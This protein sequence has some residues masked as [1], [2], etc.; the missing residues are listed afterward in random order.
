[1]ILKHYGIEFMT[2]V[3]KFELILMRPY[4]K[5]LIHFITQMNQPI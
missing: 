5:T 3:L 1:M 4:L 2:Q